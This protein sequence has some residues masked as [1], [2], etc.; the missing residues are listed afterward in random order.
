[1]FTKAAEREF[2]LEVV[3]KRLHLQQKSRHNTWYLIMMRA[4][5]PKTVQ[6]LIQSSLL[7]SLCLFK[8][9]TPILISP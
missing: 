8:L 7:S 2:H 3:V 1:M 5:T 4:H 6:M 9:K